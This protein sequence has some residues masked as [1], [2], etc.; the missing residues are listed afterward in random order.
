MRTALSQP[1]ENT[2]EP[3]AEKHVAS[4]GALPSWFTDVAAHKEWTKRVL[5]QLK[6]K[7]SIRIAT[8][9]SLLLELLYI[10]IIP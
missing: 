4:A 3:S 9:I 1:P 2:V 5:V 7:H 10:Q 8:Q 6:K